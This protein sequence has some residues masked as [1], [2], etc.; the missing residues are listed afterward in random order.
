MRKVKI[1][2]KLGHYIVTVLLLCCFCIP[3]AYA[4]TPQTVSSIETI[5]FEDGTYMEITTTSTFLLRGTIVDASKEYLCKN[6]LGDKLFSYTLYGRFEYNGSTSEAL[7]VSSLVHI[8]D[9][10]WNF[11]SKR[12]SYSGN[13]VYGSATFGGPQIKTVGGS[14]SCDKNGN[15]T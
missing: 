7:D 2:K 13:T 11:G 9:S 4:A 5:Y 3:T 8:Y 10:E 12:E 15:I 6:L 1:M 14:I